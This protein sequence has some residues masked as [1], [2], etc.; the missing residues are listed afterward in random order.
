VHV[1]AHRLD[2][3][4]LGA[5]HVFVLVVEPRLPEHLQALLLDFYAAHHHALD[6]VAHRARQRWVASA[7]GFVEGGAVVRAGRGEALEEA[8]GQRVGQGS[9]HGGRAGP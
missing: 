9:G 2:E 8:L 6:E 1:P 4:L 7:R 3:G 5:A